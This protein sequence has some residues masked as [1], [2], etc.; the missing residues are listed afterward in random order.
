MERMNFPM[1]FQRHLNLLFKVFL[2]FIKV[3]NLA[4]FLISLEHMIERLL[5]KF[6]LLNGYVLRFD[7]QSTLEIKSS[8]EKPSSFWSLTTLS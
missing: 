5:E 8:K 6:L 1:G 4:K 2:L 3:V 7:F